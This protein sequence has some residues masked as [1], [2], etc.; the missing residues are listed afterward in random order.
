VTKVVVLVLAVAVALIV[1]IGVALLLTSNKAQ[2]TVSGESGRITFQ[3]DRDGNWEIYTMNPDGSDQRN[4]TNNPSWDRWPAWS[5]DGSKIAF[6]SERDNGGDIHTMDADGSDVTRL[7]YNALATSPGWS[8]DGEKIA[9][10]SRLHGRFINEEIYVMNADGAGIQRRTYNEVVDTE[11][12]WSPDGS[13]IAFTAFSE[14]GGYDVYTMDPDGSKKVNLTPEHTVVADESPKWSP[15]GSKIVFDSSK[16]PSHAI[17][18]MGPD[19]S[20]KKVLTPDPPYDFEPAWSPDGTRIVF[21]SD[22]AERVGD[23]YQELYVMQADGSAL[24]RITNNSAN[25]WHPDWQPFSPTYQFGGFF[26]PVDKAPTLNTTKA[27]SAVPVKF[28]LSGDQGLDIFAT[29][30][31]KSQQID[32]DSAAPL[33]NIEQT[34]SA[35]SS[36]VSYDATTDRYTYAW[37]TNSDW[38]GTCRQLVVRFDDGKVYRAN[39]QFR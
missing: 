6:V 12:D 14:S 21:Q 22:R 28:S 35:G 2:A 26:S 17:W 18:T 7:T 23:G 15:D 30:Y 29:D 32:C 4:L 39:F 13:K 1:A 37:K 25:D 10:S 5:P 19:G 38:A 24:T 33:N 20:D 16:S 34:I 9:F 27:G 36:G 31:P 8:P 3:S 11:P